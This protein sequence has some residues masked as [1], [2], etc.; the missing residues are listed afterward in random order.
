[1]IGLK[2]NH[3][4]SVINNTVAIVVKIADKM[5]IGVFRAWRVEPT[6]A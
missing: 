2:N 5:D 1:M 6:I 3:V 4:V